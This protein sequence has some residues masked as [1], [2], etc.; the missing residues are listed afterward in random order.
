MLTFVL[1]EKFPF[2]VPRIFPLFPI[3]KKK[4]SKHFATKV[5][6]NVLVT[7]IGNKSL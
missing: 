7:Q 2:A 5:T 1:F 6:L 4:K 3:H